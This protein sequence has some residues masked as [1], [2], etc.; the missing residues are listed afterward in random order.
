M[1]WHTNNIR[2]YN[3]KIPFIITLQNIKY[4][5]LILIKYVHTLMQKN[6]K[7]YKNKENLYGYVAIEL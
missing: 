1:S 3:K 4:T 7:H 5:K 6:I 2:K